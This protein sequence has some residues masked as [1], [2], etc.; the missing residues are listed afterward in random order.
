MW[1][2]SRGSRRRG[3]EEEQCIRPVTVKEMEQAMGR[4]LEP[5]MQVL[6]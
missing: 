1:T 5:A 6:K 4:V 2:S 3:V